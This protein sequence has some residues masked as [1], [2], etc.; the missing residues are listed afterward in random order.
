MKS[1]A[2]LVVIIVCSTF[3]G[4]DRIVLPFKEN[5]T[6]PGGMGSEKGP[7]FVD[8]AAVESKVP[9]LKDA[10][11]RLSTCYSS[12][13]APQQLFITYRPEVTGENTGQTNVLH[14]EHARDSDELMC[15]AARN[16]GKVVFDKTP[17]KY[18]AIDNSVGAADAL[19]FIRALL[20]H[21]LRFAN[22][23]PNQR[24]EDVDGYVGAISREGSR[25]RI[26][27]GACFWGGGSVLVERKRDS[28]GKWFYEAVSNVDSGLVS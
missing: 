1:L 27:F 12:M 13:T 7:L 5:L 15:D 17:D 8:D 25:L 3:E 18:F 9:W 6:G 19:P 10:G 11:K 23:V 16:S 2:V 28:T 22:G 24:I 26:S 14:C 20:K 4:S 21:E